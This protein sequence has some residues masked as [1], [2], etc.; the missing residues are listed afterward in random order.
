MANAIGHFRTITKHRHKVIK[1]CFKAGIGF[2]GLRH[3]LSKYAPIEFLNGA[4]YYDGSRSPN[5]LER[6]DK[7]HSEA[8][9]HH[10]GRNR[11]HFEYWTDYSPKFKKNMPVK[12]PL[13]YVIEMFCDRV[14]ASKIYQGEKYTDEFPLQYFERG[15]DSRIIH[16]ETSDLL[17]K[18][19]VMLA[20]E[21]EEK[22]FAYIKNVI[23]KQK[24]Y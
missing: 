12:M 14:A 20:E 13:K 11:H 1:H 21:G 23:L 16:P 4:K 22:T 18:L 6:E 3:D 2:Q 9:M 10:K 17:E 5:E 7:G 24:N 8:W 15:R 19:L